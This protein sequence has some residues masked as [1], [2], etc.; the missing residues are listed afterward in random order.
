MP[1]PTTFINTENDLKNDIFQA[2]VRYFIWTLY[3]PTST[4]PFHPG[5]VD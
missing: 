3:L 1:Q 4:K 5:V 2:C